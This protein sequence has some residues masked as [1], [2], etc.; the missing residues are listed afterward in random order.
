MDMGLFLRGVPWRVICCELS[1]RWLSSALGTA[2]KILAR[3]LE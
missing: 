2:G 1:S 3:L